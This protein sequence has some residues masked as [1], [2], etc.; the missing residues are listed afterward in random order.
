MACP[1]FLILE[2]PLTLGNEL[3]KLA[4]N[5]ALARDVAGVHWRSDGMQGLRLGEAVAIS[6]LRDYR[7][8][9]SE[10]FSGFSLTKFDGTTITV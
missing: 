6:V 3:N 8:T 1:C 7:A 2:P 4:S 5:I 10:R 9:Y